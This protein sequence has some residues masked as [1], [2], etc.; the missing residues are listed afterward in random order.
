M[1]R[2]VRN[3]CIVA[4][5]DHGKST[6]A[7][8]LLEITGTLTKYQMKD[9]VLDAMDLEREKGITIKSHPVTMDYTAKD[10]QRYRLNLIDTPGHVDFSYE[11]SRSLAACEGAI[12]VVD[13]AQGIQ[14]QTLSNYIL[15]RDGGLRIIPVLNKID[16][17]GAYPDKI[18]EELS[19]LLEVEIDSILR[20]SAKSGIGVEEVLERVVR[21]V[22][23]PTG[24]ASGPARA[25]VFDSIFDQYRGVVVYVRVKDG[26]LK[27]GNKILFMATET[28][29]YEVLEVGVFKPAWTPKPVLHAGDVGYVIANIKNVADAR[30]GDTI[31]S[32][33]HPAAE[34]LPGYRPMKPM[35]FSGVYPVATEDYENLKEALGKL[36]LN[37]AALSYEPETSVALGFGFR[38]GF[39]GP[40]HLEIVQERLERE[41]G[42]DIIATVPNVRYEVMDTKGE[43]FFV[44]SPVA[45]PDPHVIEEIS[46]PFVKVTILVPNEYLGNIMQLT[47]DRRG[48]Y[49][50]MEYLDTERVRLVY[51]VPLTEIILDYYDKLKSLSRGYATMD[52]EYIGYRP[53]EVVRMDIRL[54]DEPVDALSVI[55]HKDKAYEWGRAVAA[56]L[57]ELIPK[58]MFQ[59]A[60]QAAIGSKIIARETI[61][62]MRKNVTA[63]CYGGDITRKRKLLE[64]QKEGK[65]R[66]KQLGTV[67]VPQEAF[68]ALLK[69]ERG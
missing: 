13:A 56:K 59:I 58:Q 64:K 21:D 39:L 47:Q 31:T 40:L 66:M 4:H 57:K 3:F 19:I 20:I 67:Q 5:V 29:Y 45:M 7:D 14:A 33:E 52:Y 51:E 17:P 6:L 28:V 48:I 27:A 68:L 42:L 55:V 18:A 35:V 65:K 2:H 69:V 37:D 62:A 24:H 46:E 8:R 34:P 50:E 9:Q 12:L 38:C 23:P 49:K 25:L 26:T 54:N 11:V 30:V 15:A 16:L 1:D 32:A 36:R 53:S 43:V 61:G 63:K 10:G 44:E 60:I 22:P 41:Y